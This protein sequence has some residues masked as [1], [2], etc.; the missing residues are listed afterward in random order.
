MTW[1]LRG[2]RLSF[3]GTLGYLDGKYLSSSSPDIAGVVARRGGWQPQDPEHAQMD[4]ER[5]VDY[6]TPAWRRPAECQHDRSRTAASSQQF[7]IASPFLDQPGFALWDANM[8]WRSHDNRYELGI[9]GKNLTNKKY[10]VS[11]IQLP[12]G[13]A[14]TGGLTSVERSAGPDPGQDR[15]CRRDSTAIRR[16]KCGCRQP[17][18]SKSFHS[19]DDGASATAP[20]FL[21]PP[22]HLRPAGN[23]LISAS[24]QHISAPPHGDVRPGLFPS[25]PG[26]GPNGARTERIGEGS[27]AALHT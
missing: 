22:E 14:V 27:G 16:A 19:R 10:V 23:R 1:Q 17:S 21:L 7:E 5:H 13:N 4:D 6:D 8:L 11:R 26:Q 18:T 20:R 2:D 25:S 24:I 12:V 9:H 3:A 15:G